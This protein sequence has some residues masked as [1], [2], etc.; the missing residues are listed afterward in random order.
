MTWWTPPTSV[1]LRTLPS[2]AYAS[3]RVRAWE[4]LAALDSLPARVMESC[5]AKTRSWVSVGKKLVDLLFQAR[6]IIGHLQVVDR[7]DLRIL[8][9]DHVGGACSLCRDIDLE[10]GEEDKAGYRRVG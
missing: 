7:C 6:D 9:E 1:R 2:G 10:R 5:V 8:P 4:R 3:A